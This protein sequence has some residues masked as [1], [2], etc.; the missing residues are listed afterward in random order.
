MKFA[1]IF[2][3]AFVLLIPVS[4]YALDF[5]DED[6][7]LY[8]RGNNGVM[9]S[10]CDNL[11][12]HIDAVVNSDDP[13]PIKIEI[14]SPSG[15]VIGVYE[16]TTRGGLTLEIDV[17]YEEE[18]QQIIRVHY[19]GEIYEKDYGWSSQYIPSR[20]SQ[21]QC[22]VAKEINNSSMEYAEI[23]IGQNIRESWKTNIEFLTSVL[24]KEKFEF[25]EPIIN[26][27]TIIDE[28]RKGISRIETNYAIEQLNLL[29]D[30]L[31]NYSKE[32]LTMNLEK[33]KEIISEMNEL[34]TEEKIDTIYDTQLNYDESFKGVEFR[35]N[36]YIDDIIF[37]YG[38]LD[39]RDTSKAEAERMSLERQMEEEL[40][41]QKI[42]DEMNESKEKI[43]E[44]LVKETTQTSD[45][46]S[47]VESEPQEPPHDV[48]L[49]GFTPASEPNC[50][51]GTILKDD[52]C[53]VDTSKQVSE[54]SSKG[55]GCL[56]ATATYGSELAPQVQQLREIR[57]NSLLQIDSGTQFMGMF[58]DIYYS[59]SPVI[60]DY[61]RENPIFKEMV[62]VAI[63]PMISSL[64]LMEYADS[65]E[66]VLGYGISL[67]IL[68]G[69]MYVG[70]PLSIVIGIRKLF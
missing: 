24:G 50:G 12:Y 22:L 32:K 67:I 4:V 31:Q 69:M 48:A 37:Q 43:Y 64:S 65:E 20:E 57:D 66:S 58:N 9:N 17:S 49:D 25:Y 19:K 59:F 41:K 7:T 13:V 29:R 2:V 44:E 54:K 55:G 61:E 15:K 14:I 39:R 46:T 34:S 45:I 70:I 3:I 68:N 53:V 6:Q 40:A 26:T 38:D 63:T 18:G 56:I 42:L 62:K 23:N 21:I 16:D 11:T 27:D 5:S 36:K 47:F 33:V 1:M 28:Q 8:F 10:T 30:I 51:A 52:Q 60:A 35:N